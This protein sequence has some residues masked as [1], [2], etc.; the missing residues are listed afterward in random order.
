MKKINVLIFPCGSE[1]AGE[2]YQALRYSIHIE[3]L[4]GASSISDHGEY[5]FDRYAGDLP[6]IDDVSFAPTFLA[7][8]K[9]NKIDIVFATHD[10]VALKL[11]ELSMQHQF[12]LI[13]GDVTTARITRYKSQT[14]NL[15]DDCDWIPHR[16]RAEDAIPCWPVIVKPDCGQGGSG[17]RCVSNDLQLQSGMTEIDDPLIVEYLPGEEITVDCF[18]DRHRQ[19]VWVGPRSRER[20]RAGIS[21][22]SQRRSSDDDIMAI[23]STINH[24]LV[25]RGPWFVQLRKDATGKWKLLEISCRIAGTMVLQRACGV[26]LPL[27]AIHDYVGRDVSAMPTPY[28][29]QIDRAIQTVSRID[30]AID[31]LYFDLDDTL[32]INGQA[33]P[34]VMALIYQYRA[35]GKRIYLITR[36][37]QDPVNTLREAAVAET[38]F[39]EIIHLKNEMDIKSDFIAENSLFVDNYFYERVDVAKINNVVV[40]DVDAVEFLLR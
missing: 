32:L 8:L 1:N 30:I 31:N 29:T 3:T 36:H 27:M 13:N 6:M 14:Y 15:F 33:V 39:D 11:A 25:F 18:T 7:L 20:I 34:A 12:G 24:R 35:K 38:L 10:S 19:L 37:M 4:M 21:M 5:R 22:R 16:Y 23:V 17:V 9:I 2:I 28:I 40:M 26:N